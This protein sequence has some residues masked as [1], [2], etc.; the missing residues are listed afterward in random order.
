[1]YD[2]RIA[3]KLGAKYKFNQWAFGLNISFPSIHIIGNADVKRKIE[4]TDFPNEEGIT[5][6]NY[7]NEFA[8]YRS[9]GFKDPFSLAFGFVYYSEN[10]KSQY[11]FTSEYFKGENT[12]MVINGK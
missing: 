6:T 3:A 8:Q 7:I 12:Y 4:L 10:K 9:S 2:D 1:M 5:E 11:Y